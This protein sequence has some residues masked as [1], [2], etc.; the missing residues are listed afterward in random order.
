MWFFVKCYCTFYIF[1]E[2]VMFLRWF[3]LIN[4]CIFSLNHLIHL[5]LFYIPNS[6]FHTLQFYQ[7]RTLYS[8]LQFTHIRHRLLSSSSSSSMALQPEVG[9]SL[10]LLGFHPESFLVGKCAFCSDWP[11]HWPHKFLLDP[12]ETARAIWQAVRRLGW[13]M[14]AWIL[15]TDTTSSIHARRFFYMP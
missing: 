1:L 9:E 11:A 15:L 3:L 2:F 5:Q 8:F 12:D 13:E 14:P 6:P 7:I 10:L 4:I